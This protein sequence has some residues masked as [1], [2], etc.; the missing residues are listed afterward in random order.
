MGAWGILDPEDRGSAEGVG[1]CEMED[2]VRIAGLLA[3]GLA[4]ALDGSEEIEVGGLAA[5]GGELLD[6]F[7]HAGV[8]GGVEEEVPVAV[9]GAGPLEGG[10]IEVGPRGADVGRVLFGVA[11]AD[12]GVGLK[13]DAEGG[14]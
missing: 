11:E 14:F 5:F 6:G 7:A 9:G 3:L 12:T 1:R 2:G 8:E 10:D 4:P 13:G